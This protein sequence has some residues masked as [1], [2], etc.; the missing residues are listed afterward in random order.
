M[1]VS[2]PQRLQNHALVSPASCQQ[3][4]L[5]AM[6][7]ACHVAGTRLCHQK[8]IKK[9]SVWGWA[10]PKPS[11]HLLSCLEPAYAATQVAPAQPCPAPGTRGSVTSALALR[12]PWA[13]RAPHHDR[14]LCWLQQAQGTSSCLLPLGM[15]NVL[16]FL[17]LLAMGWLVQGTSGNC[18]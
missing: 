8:S 7:C 5:G 12:A 4:V 17:L 13:T 9:V 3:A 16:P 10:E 6:S 14:L 1:A 2:F 18:G 15:M 11:F